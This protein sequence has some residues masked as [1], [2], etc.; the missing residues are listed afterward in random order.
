MHFFTID[1]ICQSFHCDIQDIFHWY[2][3]LKFTAYLFRYNQVV[4]ETRDKDE[5]YNN[6]SGF[7]YL[8]RTAD[9][10]STWQ[11]FRYHCLIARRFTHLSL[12]LFVSFTKDLFTLR[13]NE[14]DNYLLS[15]SLQQK[16]SSRHTGLTLMNLCGIQLMVMSLLVRSTLGITHI[17][18]KWMKKTVSLMAALNAA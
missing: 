4:N 11:L 7:S 9:T 5:E 6:G 17:D 15:L 2:I 18:W 10:C 16:E 3:G 1:P 12:S 8:P 13:K 14:S